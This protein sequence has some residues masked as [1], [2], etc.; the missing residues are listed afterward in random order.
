MQAPMSKIRVVTLALAVIVLLTLTYFRMRAQG[1]PPGPG[2]ADLGSPLPLSAPDK[3]NAPLA[4]GGKTMGTTYSVKYRPGLVGA[5]AAQQAVEAALAEVNHTFS[6]Y[7]PKSEVSLFNSAPAAQ[8]LRVTQDFLFVFQLA[9]SIHDKTSGAF[10]LTVRPLV[11]AYGFGAPPHHRGA[12]DPARLGQL[13]QIVGMHLVHREAQTLSKSKSGVQLDF[14]GIAKGFGVDRAAEALQKLGIL[15]YLVEVGGEIRVLGKKS[16]SSPWTL[17]IE[18][19]DPQRRIVHGT[20]RLSPKGGAIATSGDYRN[21]RTVGG[22]RISHTFDPRTLT[23]TPQRTA[24]VS[25][26]RPTAAEADALAT[27]LGVLTPEEAILRADKWGWAVYLLVHGK[28]PGD[29]LR[30]VQSE[31]FSLLEFSKPD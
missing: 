25:V 14:G 6:T 5:R 20:L 9:Q 10:D 2:K 27:A 21:F 15:H 12:I 28:G 3:T 11:Q 29:A 30:S 22:R 19:P 7:D 13:R 1:A 26:I 8:P 18:Q 24:S 31:A 17:A 23:P 4:F 16:E